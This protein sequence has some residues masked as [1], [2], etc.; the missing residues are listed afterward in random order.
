VGA[1]ANSAANPY[2]VRHFD[3]ANY[4]FADGHVKWLKSPN[5][6]VTY[7]VY[8]KDLDYCPGGVLGAET[9]LG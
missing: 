1:S 2:A 8:T 7:R 6:S 3:G 9:T 4:V 5:P